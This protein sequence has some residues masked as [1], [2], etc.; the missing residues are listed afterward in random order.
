MKRLLAFGALFLAA[1]MLPL[2]AG[3]QKP[4]TIRIESWLMRVDDGGN[5]LVGG[6]VVACAKVWIG[7]AAVVTGGSP[8][9]TGA[10][11]ADTVADLYGKCSSWT[12]VG[13]Y[14]FE[15]NGHLCAANADQHDHVLFARHEIQLAGGSI[16]IQFTGKYSPTFAGDG[17]WV[18]TGGTGAFAGLQGTGTWEAQGYGT[19]TGLYFMH[20]EVGTVH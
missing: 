10:S 17:H 20:T 16:L 11:Y 3:A 1:L 8:T 5:A 19:A 14:R 12:L 9:W 15:G 4:Q 6:D 7:D 2:G 18:I 13:G